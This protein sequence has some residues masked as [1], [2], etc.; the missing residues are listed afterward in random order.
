MKYVLTLEAL[1]LALALVTAQAQPDNEDSRLIIQM[2]LEP[3]GREGMDRRY[4]P[5]DQTASGW[6][7]SLTIGP[8]CA[9]APLAE[10]ALQNRETA[11]R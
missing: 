11:D 6:R 7:L 1:L 5:G 2:S 4:N 8:A 3:I 9:R 10:P